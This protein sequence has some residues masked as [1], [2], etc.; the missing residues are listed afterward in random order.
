[1]TIVAAITQGKNSR[2]RSHLRSV[3]AM[4]KPDISHDQNNRLP[5]CPP[6]SA[7]IFR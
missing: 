7:V 4:A 3:A 1:V 5:A 2:S 6:H